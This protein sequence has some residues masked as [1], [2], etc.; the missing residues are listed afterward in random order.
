M[1]IAT[2]DFAKAFDTIRHR[3]LSLLV[4]KSSPY[5]SLLKRPYAQ[6]QATDLTDK[7][8][9]VFEIK[10]VTKQGDHLS[11]LLFNTVLQAALEEET[12]SGEEPT[13]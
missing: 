12:E 9:N 6:Q 2:V 5:I 3:A 7:D 8:S 1:W 11:S 4:W 13:S 10:R